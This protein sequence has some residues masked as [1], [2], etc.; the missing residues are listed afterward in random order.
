MSSL[1]LIINEKQCMRCIIDDP[2]KVTLVEKNYFLSPVGRALFEAAQ[3][4]FTKNV[5]LTREHL[6]AEGSRRCDDVTDGVI[7]ALFDDINFSPDS[8]RQHYLPRLR[9]DYAKKMLE[10]EVLKEAIAE[11]MSKDAL[12]VGNVRRIMQRMQEMVELYEGKDSR[13]MSLD[14]AGRVYEQRLRD[15]AA[16]MR[17]R[18]SDAHLNRCLVAGLPPKQ[19]TVAFGAT[20]VGKSAFALHLADRDINK[21]NPAAYVSLEMDLISTFD[22]LAARRLGIPLHMLMPGPDTGQVEPFVLD[23]VSAEMERLRRVESFF[24]I[25][26]DSLCISDIEQIAKEVKRRTKTDYLVLYLDL[27]TMLREFSGEDANEYERGMNLLHEMVRR[28]GVHAVNVV[29]AN[30]KA[31]DVR[32][33]SIDQLEMLRPRR[34]TIK[35]SQ[36]ILERCR[37]QLSV[38]RPR[39]YA[40]Q[41]FHEDPA[42]ADMPDTMEVQVLKQTMGPVGAIIKYLY[43]GELFQLIPIR[44]LPPDLENASPQG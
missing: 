22:R 14:Q 16:L 13:I 32:I 21:R 29:Q 17:F 23:A 42:L 33:T 11:S 43:R 10:D 36:A 1:A 44:D 39:Y 7:G 3:E 15:R 12:D 19:M 4:L 18:V 35:N 34:N 6:L 24:F 40:E 9:S 38:F 2:D 25:E 20:G 28:Q 41:L 37:N 30:R 27:M 26:D 31:D 5:P 8:F